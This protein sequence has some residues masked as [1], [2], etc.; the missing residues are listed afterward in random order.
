MEYLNMCMQ[1]TLTEGE[2]LPFGNT[3]LDLLIKLVYFVKRLI[4]FALSK[5]ADLN[6]LVQGGQLY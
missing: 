1:G 3:Q 5:A 6:C 4:T 2:G